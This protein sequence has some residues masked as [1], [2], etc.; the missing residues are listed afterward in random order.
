MIMSHL[1]APANVTPNVRMPFP[2]VLSFRIQFRCHLLQKVF[3]DSALH[4]HTGRSLLGTS[5]SIT[6]TTL[7]RS[8]LWYGKPVSHT[9]LGLG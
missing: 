5:P 6:H 9:R 3:Q 2:K 7:Y 8:S 1:R 4:S